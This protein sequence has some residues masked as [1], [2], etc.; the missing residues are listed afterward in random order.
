MSNLLR[1]FPW[2]PIPGSSGAPQWDGKQFIVDGKRQDMLCYEFAESHWTSELTELHEAEAGSNHP[3]D[4]ASRALAI[5]SIEQFL[6]HT[7]VIVLDV[8][9]SSGFLL[10]ELRQRLPR[11]EL[12]GSD[13]IFAPLKGRLRP[14]LE[15]PLL[16]F[17]LRK[18]PLPDACIDGVTAL[19]VLEHIDDD[20]TALRHIWRMLKPNGVAHIEVP[21]GP[22]LYDI[23]DEH[24]MHHR[25][26]TR[27]QLKSLAREVG[28][29]VVKAT[30]LG[31]SVYPA[32][33]WVKRKNRRLLS[34]PAEEKKRLVAGQIR[35]T[36]QSAFLRSLLRAEMAV[37]KHVSYKRGIRCLAVL[38]KPR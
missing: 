4:C 7:N 22:H 29:E 19:N 37:G 11:I 23:Y 28:F 20:K 34:R 16:Q 14:L 21:A 30:H 38:R 2:P 33:A 12:I 3:I 13:F 18:C 1:H 9:C 6:P 31:A 8:G 24:L 27:E 32:F 35:T 25:R 36:S 26:Y 10:E 5:R 15:V 17:D